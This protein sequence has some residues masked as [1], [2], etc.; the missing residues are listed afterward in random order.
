MWWACTAKNVSGSKRCRG[1]ATDLVDGL[2]GER[3]VLVLSQGG[4]SEKSESGKECELHVVSWGGTGRKC[5][6][7]KRGESWW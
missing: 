5:G 7:E 4:D 2:L 1:H 3:E 6:E